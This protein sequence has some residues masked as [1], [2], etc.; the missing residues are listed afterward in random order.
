[1]IDIPLFAICF[2]SVLLVMCVCERFLNAMLYLA[3][4]LVF[5]KSSKGAYSAM[6]LCA[7][8]ATS[9]LKIS[10]IA[11]DFVA[12]FVRATL[13]TAL[14]AFGFF[15]IVMLVFF[16]Y[17][18]SPGSLR[19]FIR[20]WNTW[21]GPMFY[22]VVVWPLRIVAMGF[23]AVVPVWNFIVKIFG[24]VFSAVAMSAVSGMGEALKGIATDFGLLLVLLGKSVVDFCQRV[25]VN[26]HDCT[27]Q[28]CYELV[29]WEIAPAMAFVAP[30]TRDM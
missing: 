15:S 28:Q 7:S 17:E 24:Q 20:E 29:E 14:W 8:V 21:M 5:N 12:A 10:M 26:V 23:S 18:N 2:P 11:S 9:G 4:S 25:H 3:M 1:M 6:Q 19:P 27:T 22:F 30:I 16:F 13:R